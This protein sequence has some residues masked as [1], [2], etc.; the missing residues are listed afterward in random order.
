MPFTVKPSR[1]VDRVTYI[2]Y[3]KGWKKKIF[4][5]V[6]MT[7]QVVLITYLASCILRNSKTPK[8]FQDVRAGL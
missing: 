4:L 8:N 1:L 7:Q 6:L 5:L 3:F 2:I